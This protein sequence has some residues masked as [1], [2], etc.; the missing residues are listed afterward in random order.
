MKHTKKINL[1]EIGSSLDNDNSWEFIEEQVEKNEKFLLPQKHFLYFKKEKRKGKTVTL[2]GEF[3]LSKD[4]IELLLKEFKK[5]LG[6]GGSFKNGFLE[7]QGE[8]EIKLKE[9]LLDK[10]FR[11]K[12]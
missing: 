7:F 6:V 1:F 9:L 11:F 5:R 10:E 4:E 3:F 12:K 8:C 2:V